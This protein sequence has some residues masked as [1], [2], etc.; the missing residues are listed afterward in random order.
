MSY[1]II[2]FYFNLIFYTGKKLSIFVLNNIK[3]CDGKFS[4][5]FTTDPSVVNFT[6][7]SCIA[8]TLADPQSAKRRICLYCLSCTFGSGCVKAWHKWNWPKVSISITFNEQLLDLQIPKA[9][10]DMDDFTVLLRFKG[11]HPNAV[12]IPALK[13]FWEYF[14][15]IEQNLQFRNC[16]STEPIKNIQCRMF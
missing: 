5:D 16:I 9:Q 2:L 12:I 14:W 11:V 1:K 3:S 13:I 10:K 15:Y 8:F 4:C 6:N 7:I